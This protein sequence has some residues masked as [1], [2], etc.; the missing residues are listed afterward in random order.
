M[1]YIIMSVLIIGY[2][3]WLFGSVLLIAEGDDLKWKIVGLISVVLALAVLLWAYEKYNSNDQPCAI[4]KTRLEY[5][6]ALKM[7]M[8]MK[9]CAERGEWINNA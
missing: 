6:P 2:I 9:Y 5:N 7:T 1:N 3:A 4:Y 8:P